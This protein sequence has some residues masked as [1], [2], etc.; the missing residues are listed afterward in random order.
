VPERRSIHVAGF[1]HVNPI[2][3]GCQF[4][5]FLITG[6]ITGLDAT[7]GKMGETLEDQCATIFGHMREIV[8]QA[9][10]GPENIVKVTVWHTGILN[11]PA[12]RAILNRQWLQ[13]FP[14]E[15][16]RPA[17]HAVKTELEPG[18]HLV[19]DMMAILGD[20]T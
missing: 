19:C 9:G 16:S 18:R 3:A 1:S 15:H 11:D 14:D 8:A 10:G 7:T 2:P 4:G 12:S 5:N 13:M 17:R 6:A 20:R